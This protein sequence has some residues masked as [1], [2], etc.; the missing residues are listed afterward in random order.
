LH[1]YGVTAVTPFRDSPL[2]PIDAQTRPDY[3]HIC[4]YLV[5]QVPKG[6]G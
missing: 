4:W 5:G 6:P 2:K 1:N 3:D